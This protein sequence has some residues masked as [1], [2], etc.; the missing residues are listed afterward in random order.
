MITR[1]SFVLAGLSITA[2]SILPLPR[3]AWSQRSSKE[4]VQS[5]PAY[6]LGASAIT[7]VYG[8]GQRLTAVAIE[9]N[10]PVEAAALDPALF[11]VDGRTIARI[12]ANSSADL[13]AEGADQI[14]LGRFVT[15]E[16]SPEDETARL[17][18]AQARGGIIRRPAA[19]TLTIT[20]TDVPEPRFESGD[21]PAVSP[22]QDDGQLQG[23]PPGFGT[24]PLSLPTTAARNLLRALT[25]CNQKQG[26]LLG[27][28]KGFRYN[29][30]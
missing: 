27:A 17:Y 7:Q 4:A 14:A 23:G 22:G 15:I 12:Y 10:R 30:N 16:L 18:A 9:Y 25:L 19:A 11:A 20:L 1:R 21:A 29:A 3:S 6:I 24:E 26:F 8:D 13:V 5:D 28:D 2:A